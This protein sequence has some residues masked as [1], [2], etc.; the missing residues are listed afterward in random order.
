MNFLGKEVMNRFLEEIC[1]DVKIFRLNETSTKQAI[2]LKLLNALGWNVFDIDEVRPE[3]G[4]ES[5]R[6]D[7]ALLIN[8]SPKVF[9][10]VKKVGE[11]L[12]NHQEQLLSY[13]FEEGVGLAVL[14]NGI[15]WWFYLPLKEG[16]WKQRRF[17][18]INLL[19][20][21]KEKV[22][23]KF[24]DLLSKENIKTGKALKVAE[25]IYKEKIQKFEI[26]K[27]IPRA[28]N[29]LLIEPD[30]L[31]VELLA[32]ITEKLCGYKPEESDIREF[33][34]EHL[35]SFLVDELTVSGNRK[36]Y[37]SK[38]VRLKGNLYMTKQEKV[39]LPPDGTLCRFKY[40]GKFY[41]GKILNQRIVVEGIGEFSSLST[42]ATAITKNSV[43]GWRVWEFKLPHGSE[44]VRADL[45]RKQRKS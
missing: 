27:A 40:K 9:I 3:Y 11:S 14:T 21:D 33:L 18:T 35:D 22:A 34:R 15:S 13:S 37:S 8:H 1:R 45:W 32:E 4:V 38:N 2:V 29:K 26:R 23:Q 20:Q 16:T 36:R 31:F 41:F 42:A 25:Q 7:Y 5:K 28:W 12:E 6:V 19:E 43:N 24:F 17:Y 10:E 30:E 44:W 39:K